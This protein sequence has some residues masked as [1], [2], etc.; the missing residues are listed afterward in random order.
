MYR[1]TML[2]GPDIAPKQGGEKR[3]IDH[4]RSSVAWSRC[5]LNTRRLPWPDQVI[6]AV[7]RRHG[8]GCML[9]WVESDLV[10][11]EKTINIQASAR[12]SFFV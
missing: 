5:F 12:L 3:S 8:V 4:G 6:D 10:L 1:H 9:D 2:H 11:K 7:L